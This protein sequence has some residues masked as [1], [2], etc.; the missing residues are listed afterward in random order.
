MSPLG[1]HRP[2]FPTRG[3]AE[4][5]GVIKTHLA[6][7]IIL[8][9][10][11]ALKGRGFRRWIEIDFDKRFELCKR[12]PSSLHEPNI[13]V[14]SVVVAT[15][16]GWTPEPAAACLVLSG[17]L[18]EPDVASGKPR[19]GESSKI[20]LLWNVGW[21]T[22]EYHNPHN[23]TLAINEKSERLAFVG[24]GAEGGWV[25]NLVKR[26]ILL[27][28]SCSGCLISFSTSLKKYTI[29]LGI[30]QLLKM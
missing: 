21:Y 5:G 27:E 6:K 1:I 11:F 26:G 17:L 13:S 22:L 8:R 25:A 30:P 7:S 2:T 10:P 14:P 9:R 3:I 16:A 24:G 4:G 19:R 18:V 29:L 23:F 15:C 28:G 12:R 20:A